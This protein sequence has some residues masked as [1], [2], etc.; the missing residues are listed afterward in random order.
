MTKRILG[1]GEGIEK[2]VEWIVP[3][4][5]GKRVLDIG[6]AGERGFDRREIWLHG[7]LVEAAGECVGLDRN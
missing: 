1:G 7:Y 3:F 6:F 4:V 2:K 5:R